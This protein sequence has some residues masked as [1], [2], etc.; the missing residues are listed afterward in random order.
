MN[1]AYWFNMNEILKGISKV[2]I[3]IIN[4]PSK[5]LPIAKRYIIIIRSSK[6]FRNTGKGLKML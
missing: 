3:Q 4:D 1:A 2:S 6:Y 5:D